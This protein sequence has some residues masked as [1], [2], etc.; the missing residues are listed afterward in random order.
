MGDRPEF[1]S[2]REAGRVAELLAALDAPAPAKPA[3]APAAP[4]PRAATIVE[5]AKPT[6]RALAFAPRPPRRAVEAKALPAE[7]QKP[8]RALA[9][10]SRP[11]SAVLQSVNW[12]NPAPRPATIPA[13]PR[14]KA[15]AEPQ[16]R[17]HVTVPVGHYQLGE[18]LASFNWLNHASPPPLPERL[19]AI[20]LRKPGLFEESPIKPAI[21]RPALKVGEVVSQFD[22]D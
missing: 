1:L 15:P 2:L 21:Q 17:R 11:A 16:P 9:A 12:L 19:Q 14:T 5:P 20:W 4:P 3:P 13:P 10:S 8:A 18:Y 6:R 7:Y 22:F